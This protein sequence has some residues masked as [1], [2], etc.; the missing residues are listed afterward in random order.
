MYRSD[1]KP[2]DKGGAMA[3]VLAIHAGLAFAFLNLSGRIDLTDPQRTLQIFDIDV[4]ETPPPEPLPPP[5]QPSQREK[6]QDK[7][8]PP[9]PHTRTIE[10][11]PNVA[12]TPTHPPPLP[13]H[14]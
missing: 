2:K 11:N 14:H 12:P 6:P 10:P 4:I 8:C 13:P 5:V 9:S 7:E 3:A 1:L